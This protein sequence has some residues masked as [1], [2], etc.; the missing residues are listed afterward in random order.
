MCNTLKHFT[1]AIITVHNEIKWIRR[2]L[3]GLVNQ[4]TGRFEVLVIDDGS[5]DAITS[6]LEEVKIARPPSETNTMSVSIPGTMPPY[7]EW[8]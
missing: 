5:D 8:P 7:A 1:T 6:W 3:D 4:A 2:A